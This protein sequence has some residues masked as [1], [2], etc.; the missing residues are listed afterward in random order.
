M[1]ITG[2]MSRVYAFNPSTQEEEIGG[3]LSLHQTG[4]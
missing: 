4:L 2:K 3:F 1:S